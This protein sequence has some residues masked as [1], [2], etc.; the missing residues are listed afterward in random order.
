MVTSWLGEGT[1]LLSGCSVGVSNEADGK[2]WHTFSQDGGFTRNH[3][4]V[5]ITGFDF[6]PTRD[7]CYE[8][9]VRYEAKYRYCYSTGFLI[10]PPGV[11]LGWTQLTPEF[12]IVST[13]AVRRIT[14]NTNY[15]GG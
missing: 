3:Y 7:R 9:V 14:P 6:L 11:C 10:P 1:L 15:R 13:D 12:R 2:D 8:M 5:N 4:M